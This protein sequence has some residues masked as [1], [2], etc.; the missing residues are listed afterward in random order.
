MPYDEGCGAERARLVV[1]WNRLQILDFLSNKL[2]HGTNPLQIGE[3]I[4]LA[5]LVEYP[6]SVHK[7]LH[8]G[9]ASRGD[10]YRSIGSEVP[11]K[12]IR[13]PRGGTEVLSTDAV[14]DLNLD[15]AFHSESS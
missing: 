6:L 4:V 14:G 3:C 15:F 7:D 10:R 12:L 9:L 13:H 1:R 2:Q 5:F 11:E 8:D